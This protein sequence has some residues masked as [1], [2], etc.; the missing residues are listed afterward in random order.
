MVPSR[1]AAGYPEDGALPSAPRRVGPRRL[2]LA[3][4]ARREPRHGAGAAAPPA[5][6]PAP[7]RRRR[8]PDPAVGGAAGR[9]R[10]P[11]PRWASFEV[12]P[13]IG[14]IHLPPEVVGLFAAA[15]PSLALGV[16]P[17]LRP[18]LDVSGTWTHVALFRQAT[19]GLSGRGVVVGIVDTGLDVRHP[20]FRTVDGHTRVAWML[21]S[22]FPVGRHP[23]IEQAFG[24]T[25]LEPVLVRGLR[26][27]GH[28]RGDHRRRGPARTTPTGTAPTS[29][30]SPPATG[31]SRCPARRAT[32][33]W[34]PRRR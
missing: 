6:P 33:G 10:R 7:P 3:A 11:Q 5:G 16:T 32:W 34:R 25:D 31:A 12:A 8:R 2:P 13:G 17:H 4:R 24:C 27:G 26:G 15:N 30:R 29:P 20:D 28:R 18:L 1:T 14:A 19:G 23:E 22:G 21:V 9:R